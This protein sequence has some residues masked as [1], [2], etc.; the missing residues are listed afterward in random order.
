MTQEDI[1]TR[2]AA[3]H[4]G[5]G[6]AIDPLTIMLILGVVT[7]VLKMWKECKK[8]PEEITFSCKNPTDKDIAL[9]RRQIRKELGFYRNWRE[10]KKLLEHT[11]QTASELST[12]EV[13]ELVG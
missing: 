2:I 11:L 5:E 10:G 12:E 1:A 8:E 4:V 7:Q 3:K 9:L 6:R 13:V